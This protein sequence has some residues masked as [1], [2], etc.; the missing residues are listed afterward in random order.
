MRLLHILLPFVLVSCG[1]GGDGDPAPC[2]TEAVLFIQTTWSANGI[3][4]PRIDAKVN[5]PL[6]ATP[7]IRGI[8]P[9]CQG[10]GRFSLGSNVA[11]PTGLSLNASSGVVLGTPTQTISVGAPHLVELSLP[12]YRTVEV[13]GIINISP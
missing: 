9:S 5:V 12:G 4:G 8:P 1:G 13:L 11:L 6:L 2:S 10:Q 7:T 3:V